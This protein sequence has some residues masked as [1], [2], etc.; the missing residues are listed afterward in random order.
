MNKQ[1]FLWAGFAVVVAAMALVQFIP[2]E[3]V[4][5]PASLPQQQR[6]AHRIVNFEG[7]DNFRDLGG[8][9][10]ADGRRVKWGVLY[11]SGTFAETSRADS[12]VLA[13]MGLSALIDF[14]S[15]SEK[16]EEPSQLPDP[17]PFEVIEIP[18]LDGGDNSVADEIMARIEEGNFQDFDPDGFMIEANR[19]FADQFTPQYREFI[20]ALLQV[21]GKPVVW[22]CSAGKDRTGYAAAIILRILGVPME[23]IYADYMLSKEPAVRARQRELKLLRL[24]K[25]DEAADKLT[26]LL[27]VERDW[28]EAGFKQIDARWGSF[29]NYVTEGLQLTDAQILQLQNTL[30]E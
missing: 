26:V 11:R 10:S 23:T 22:H 30:L 1:R 13:T 28:L 7:V 2:S 17:V 21:Q 15:T 9:Q 8:Y 16:E 19:Q 18:T 6:E 25:G 5:L 14:R 12:Q 24:F 4:I 3:P 29:D 27:G 20:Q